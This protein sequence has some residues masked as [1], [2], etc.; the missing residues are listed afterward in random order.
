MDG[1]IEMGWGG[2]D[3]GKKRETATS[4]MSSPT[5]R[6]AIV[7]VVKKPPQLQDITASGSADLESALTL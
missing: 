4:S 1:W 6:V 7:V 2:T 3:G 5:G